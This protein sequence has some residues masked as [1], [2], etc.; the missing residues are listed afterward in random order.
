MPSI[1]VFHWSLW[2]LSLVAGVGAIL[3]LFKLQYAERF[4][5]HWNE[6]KE[7]EATLPVRREEMRQATEGIDKGET[8]MGD[9]FGSEHRSIVQSMRPLLPRSAPGLPTA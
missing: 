5:P 2:G 8:Q 9:R 7:L 1:E 4:L 3:A 6:L